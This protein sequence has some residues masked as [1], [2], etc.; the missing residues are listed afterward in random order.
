MR[1][2]SKNEFLARYP[3]AKEAFGKADIPWS[4]LAAIYS[5]HVRRTEDLHDTGTMISEKLRR[6]PQVHSLRVRVK[7]PEHLLEKIIRKT[8][9]ERRINLSNYQSE[10]TDL[11]GVR[12]LH[13]FKHEWLAIHERICEVW[14]IEGKPVANIRKGDVASHY[15]EKDCQIVE[16]EA[17][18]RSVHY[19]VSSSPTKVTT[20]TE[21]QVRTLFEE[22][23][24]EIDHQIRYPYNLKDT[25]L[26]HF[27]AILNRLAGSA[28]EMGSFITML[29][30]EREVKERQIQDSEEEKYRVIDALNEVRKSF[31]AS[32]KENRQLQ[33]VIETLKAQAKTEELDLIMDEMA[34]LLK[35]DGRKPEGPEL[36]FPEDDDCFYVY[37]EHCGKPYGIDDLKLDTRICP[38]CEAKMDY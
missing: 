4:E 14:K 16:H 35:G 26:N 5:D 8:T 34:E 11:V 1:P 21:V 3:L 23:W 25:L 22:G 2:P 17:G 31:D 29:M 30:K 19:L 6:I 15:E 20:I 37:C 9:P 32:T 18:Y 13:L 24:S 7:D 36:P 27:L 38:M 10:I 28:D 12:A 33:D